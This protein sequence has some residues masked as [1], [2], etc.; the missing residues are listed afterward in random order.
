MKRMIVA[1]VALIVT[2]LSASN[3]DALCQFSKHLRVGKISI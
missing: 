1:V 3:S 2:A